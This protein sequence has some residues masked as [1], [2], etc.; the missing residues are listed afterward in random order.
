[1][2]AGVPRRVR[3]A[4]A[5]VVLAAISTSC[6]NRIS[7]RDVVAAAARGARDGLASAP[8]ARVDTYG[9]PG[10][11]ADT[12]P[13]AADAP[14]TGPSTGPSREATT[15]RRATEESGPS[16]GGGG[17]AGSTTRSPVTV[18]WVG[19]LSGPAGAQTQSLYQ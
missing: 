11:S 8:A 16:L 6:G 1:M 2:L 5:V 12:G 14:S 10:A 3:S 15:L 7:H 9:P 18:A 19:H 13:P 4:A 17:A